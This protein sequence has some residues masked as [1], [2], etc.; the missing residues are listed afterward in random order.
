MKS[1]QVKF[2]YAVA[3]GNL[4][5]AQQQLLPQINLWDE[6]LSPSLTYSPAIICLA[7]ASATKDERQFC[8]NA[9]K[10][11]FPHVED[12]FDSSPHGADY[13][14]TL[15]SPVDCEE[16]IRALVYPTIKNSLIQF[17]HGSLKNKVKALNTDKI[18]DETALWII[19][20]FRGLKLILTSPDFADV[21]FIKKMAVESV[22]NVIKNYIQQATEKLQSV[23]PS[24]SLPKE[25][26][27]LHTNTPASIQALRNCSELDHDALIASP[28]TSFV[29]AFGHARRSHGTWSR[30]NNEMKGTTEDTPKK[31]KILC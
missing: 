13:S 7:L 29:V 20:V 24:D 19:C 23:L 8:L 9:L 1:E 10:K 3:H 31:T 16:I 12:P 21:H 2:C 25:V 4:D 28:S 11:L 22:Y 6:D 14:L 5:V 17:L 18:D 26:N 30:C 15:G 27:E